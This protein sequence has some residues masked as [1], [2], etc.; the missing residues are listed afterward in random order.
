MSLQ[1]NAILP[2][3]SSS[4]EPL[5]ALHWTKTNVEIRHSGIGFGVGFSIIHPAAATG[6][7]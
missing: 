2:N 5:N 3:W 1:N 7:S 6:S 4:A